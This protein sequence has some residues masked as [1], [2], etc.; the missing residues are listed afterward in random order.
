MTAV[1][2][3]EPVPDLDLVAAALR[4]DRADVV[5]FTHVLGATLGDSLPPGMVEVERARSAADRLRGRPGEP[6][7]VRVRTPD[8]ELELRRGR[9]GAVEAEVR[10]VVRGVVISRRPV[11][12]DEW[13]R[14]LAEELTKL[15]AHDAAARGAL[16][17]LLGA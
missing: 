4:A 7:T 9:H 2:D 16:A 3:L 1:G 17:R 15:A 8:R 5:T 10:Q 13:T 14:T 11:D 6:T 12:L